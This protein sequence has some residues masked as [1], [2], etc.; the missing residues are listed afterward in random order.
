MPPGYGARRFFK[1]YPPL[2]FS[3]LL[4]TPVYI[5]QS[6]DYSY[7]STA[8]EWLVGVPLLMP[9]SGKLN[10]VMWSLVCEVQFYLVL[11]LIMFLFHRVSMRKS[12][13]L[14][15]LLLAVTGFGLR[16]LYGAF[17]VSATLSPNLF[18]PF[19][20]HLDMFAV[21]VLVAGLHCMGA[22]DRSWARVGNVGLIV[23]GIMLPVQAWRAVYSHPNPVDD[24]TVELVF[25][26]A[27]GCTLLF[28]ADTACI[29]AR[30]LCHPLLRYF[31]VIS[32]EWYLFHQPLLLWTRSLFGSAGG[33][34]LL[35]L[36]IVFTPILV[37]LMLAAVVYKYYS[38]PILKYGRSRGKALAI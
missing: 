34:F 36:F 13:V 35:Y 12:I 26:L 7:L 37:S 24:E 20:S 4:L 27:F 11:P 32:Y 22:I 19:L 14:I 17:G 33:N 25:K 2:V 23:V 8:A 1:I 31:G 30:M 16:L 38:L 6:S 3:I 9:V 10:P 29:S 21:G 15:P 5:Y 28:V 18:M